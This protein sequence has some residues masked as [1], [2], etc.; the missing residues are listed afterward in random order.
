MKRVAFVVIIVFLLL[1]IAVTVYLVVTQRV[2][3][4][5]KAA[6]TAYPVNYCTKAAYPDRCS[7]GPFVEIEQVGAPTYDANSKIQTFKLR[8]KRVG[9]S[10]NAT[11]PPTVTP[12]EVQCTSRTDCE[13][14][15][16]VCK[17]V[18][19]CMNQQ[20]VFI[21]RPNGFTC[22]GGK[23]QEG[24]CVPNPTATTRPT[25]TSAP[26]AT[27][28]PAPTAPAATATR[29]AATATSAP[30]E[31]QALGASINA[32]IEVLV[33]GYACSNA[34]VGQC[35]NCGPEDAPNFVRKEEWI[36]IPAG[37]NTS[38]DFNLSV[39]RFGDGA[40]CGCV[41]MDMY[42]VDVKVNGTSVGCPERGNNTSGY[43]CAA[44]N[45]G[46]C[47]GV[48][49][50]NTPRPRVSPTVTV[51]QPT[52]TPVVPTSP[53]TGNQN[54][55]CIELSASP[56]S[57]T[58][59]LTVHFVGTGQ[60]SDGPIK[61]MEFD[62]GDGKPQTIEKDVGNRGSIEIDHTYTL[63]GT[64]VASLRVADNQGA[65]SSPN[66]NCRVEID[67][68][69]GPT[70]SPR[71]TSTPTA[72]GGTGPTTTKVPTASPIPT[73]VEPNVP[74]SGGIGQTMLVGLSGLL[75]IGLG[76]LFAL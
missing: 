27:N 76:L 33:V 23:C 13:P 52:N 21:N 58:A 34:T 42:I 9:A 7:G 73:A 18:S 37:A 65:W 11:N 51:P 14:K 3:L 46:D 28:T 66:D 10:V 53:P 50:T 17:Q 49:P 22:T 32:T 43:L 35:S 62:Y 1:S 60:D 54:P 40:T 15:A 16:P 61:K 71:P 70:V 68:S 74:V 8:A 24:A 39:S 4:R 64:F 72:K 48:K 57:G 67:P 55:E 5:K 44:G 69:G 36:K 20:C 47:G 45:G 19:A 29:P 63:S 56:I 75:V 38:G 31:G 26:R 6:P 59:P 2:E 12:H 41:Q 30:A 25:A